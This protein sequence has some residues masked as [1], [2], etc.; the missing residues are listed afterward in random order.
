MYTRLN[1]NSSFNICPFLEWLGAF[2]PQ[3]QRLQLKTKTKQFGPLLTKI[4]TIMC[5]KGARSLLAA[6]LN[7]YSKQRLIRVCGAVFSSSVSSLSRPGQFGHTSCELETKTSCYQCFP[8]HGGIHTGH[9]LLP[10]VSNSSE[11]QEYSFLAVIS[12]LG[13]PSEKLSGFGERLRPLQVLSNDWGQVST[14]ISFNIA[15]SQ[16]RC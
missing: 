6:V 11:N 13:G 8:Q 1:W 3:S 2:E 7:F 15:I 9:F 16:N 5:C 12:C 10:N 4:Q 14:V